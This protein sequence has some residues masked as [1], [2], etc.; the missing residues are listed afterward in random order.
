[1]GLVGTVIFAGLQWQE[2]NKVADEAIYQRVAS[3][4]KEHLTLFIENPPLR[5]YF[6]EKKAL[7]ENDP[8]RDSVLAAADLRL[9]AMDSIITYLGTRW[10]DSQFPQWDDTIRHV[11]RNSSV[12][13]A[14]LLET[15]AMW[16]EEMIDLAKESCE[17]NQAPTPQSN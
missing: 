9:Q 8:L 14:R 4:W 10:S 16:D 12:L 1:M 17:P 5:S 6:E 7:T 3:E 11:F 15:K 13:C 2:A